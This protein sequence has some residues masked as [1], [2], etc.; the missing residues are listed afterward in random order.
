MPHFVPQIGALQAGLE[1]SVL[2]EIFVK[3][4]RIRGCR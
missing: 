1:P 4:P 2:D 3:I